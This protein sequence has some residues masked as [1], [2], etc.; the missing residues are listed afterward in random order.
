LR[1]YETLRPI[2]E[3]IDQLHGFNFPYQLASKK[4]GG[5]DASLAICSSLELQE[6]DIIVLYSDGLADNLF[7]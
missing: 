6:G 7:P 4:Y 1:K 3:T 5:D 2:F